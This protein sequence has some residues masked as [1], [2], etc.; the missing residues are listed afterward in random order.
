MLC[1]NSSTCAD[2]TGLA[3]LKEYSPLHPSTIRQLLK[4]A[5]D[6]TDPHEDQFWEVLDVIRDTSKPVSKQQSV[7]EETNAKP[8]SG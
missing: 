4:Y 5:L 2:V 6:H 8:P 1:S 7:E 3:E